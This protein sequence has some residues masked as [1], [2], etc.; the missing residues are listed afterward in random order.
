M[1]STTL[2]FVR[3]A[4][5]SSMAALL[6]GTLLSC[7]S[8]QKSMSSS[9][10][11]TENAGNFTTTVFIGDSLTA[12]FQNGSLLDTQQPNGWANLVATQAKA[13]IT[14]P[15]IAPPGAPAVLQL[16]SLG[17]P[18]V[19]NSASGVTTGR[20][21]PSAQ[22]T[23][24]A[25]PGHKLND[26]IN[27]APTAAPSTAEDIITN[28]V[29][30]FPLGNSNTQ[31]QEAVALQPTTLFVWI[32]ANDAL[33]ADDTGMPSSMTQVS[34]FTTLYT[35]MMQTLTTKTKANLIVA[36][37][38]DVTLSPV[39]TPAATVLAEI[40]ASSGIPQATLSAMLGITAGDLVNATG[41]QEAQKIVASQQQG[42][43]DDAGFLSAAEVLQVQQTIDQYN[44][45]I[46][47]QVAAAG[48]TLVD[49]HALFAKLAAGITINNYN[50]SLN[51][52]GGLVGLDGVHPTNTGYAL[53]A[54]EF[55]DTM[56]S[57]LK[58]TIPDVDVSAIASADPLFGPN[59]KPSG[60]PNVMIPLN[61]AQ[62]AGDMIRGWKPR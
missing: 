2:H 23:D 5:V 60:S 36:N 48:G 4:A 37:I 16:V 47:Q 1:P 22:P 13:A 38:P 31:L 51:F 17:P 26:L 50:A 59:I 14:L 30:G 19:I 9:G 32:G 18:P 21:N 29:L 44:Q 6:C 57:S 43:I 15:L 12:G 39:L 35:Q 10:S 27:A 7:G 49:I 34:S 46:A 8:S 25:V 28:L 56:N 20:D 58:T 55:I 53:V 24:L 52:L 41:L 3:K 45:V 62:R 33:V 61:A 11:S 40:S 54:N 42:P